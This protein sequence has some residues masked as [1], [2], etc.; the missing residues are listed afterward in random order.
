MFII[1]KI[2]KKVAQEKVAIDRTCG[3]RRMT[4]GVKVGR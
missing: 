1:E 4:Q 2:E 3:H